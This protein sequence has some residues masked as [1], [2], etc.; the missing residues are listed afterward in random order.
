MKIY[1][2]RNGGDKG[3]FGNRAHV[4]AGRSSRMQLQNNEKI[5][6]RIPRRS[7]G[8]AA[9]LLGAALVLTCLLLS[10][11][12]FYTLAGPAGENGERHCRITVSP[13]T[14][15]EL[16]NLNPGDSYRRTLTVT[17]EGD[18]PAYLWLRHEWVDGD[19]LPGE[20]GDLFSQ[21]LLNISWRNIT[22]YNGPAEGLAEPLNISAKIGPVRPGQTLDLDFFIFLPGP[23]T[24]NEFQGS[25][26]TTKII[27]ITACGNGEEDPPDPPGTDPPDLPRTGGLTLVL[28]LLLG[29]I[30]ILLG[31]LLK[32][33]AA[34]EK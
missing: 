13:D 7:L 10:V 6:N 16:G 29:F 23:P 28:L 18:L 2:R 14:L 21:L 12:P 5:M 3:S 22:L 20:P 25:T 27:L 30:F 15:F 34:E 1:R 32:R 9:I 19:P 17:D 4:Y 24:G 11:Q 31:L 8:S 33:K 26:V